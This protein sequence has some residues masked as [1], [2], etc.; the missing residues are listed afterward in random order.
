MSGLAATG[1]NINYSVVIPVYRNESSLERLVERLDALAA[2]LAGPRDAVFV[3]AGS[4]DDSL[5]RLR[6]IVATGRLNAQILELSRN[7]GSFAAIRSGMRAARGRY[8]GV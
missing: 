5:R 6:S 4:P 2:T 3:V 1:A 7:F 8:L